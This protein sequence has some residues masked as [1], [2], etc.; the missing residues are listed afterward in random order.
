MEE[1]TNRETIGIGCLASVGASIIVFLLAGSVYV[2]PFVFVF[3]LLAFPFSFVGA[4]IG[5]KLIKTRMGIWMGAI[6]A[7]V[8]ELWLL[9][10]NRYY[11][12][13]SD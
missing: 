13:L 11:L 8:L 2:I 3:I 7:A 6:V 9:Y 5:K 10:L 12:I 4:L 1:I